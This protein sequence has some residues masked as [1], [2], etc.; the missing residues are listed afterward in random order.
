MLT[1]AKLKRNQ[2][3]CVALTGLIPKEFEI[4]LPVFTR[5]YAEHYPDEKT[6]SGKPR[7]RQVG[8]G[9]IQSAGLVS[10]GALCFDISYALQ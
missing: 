5:A 3:R 9:A 2:R 6:V 4:L 8:G 10:N 1:Y 7:Q